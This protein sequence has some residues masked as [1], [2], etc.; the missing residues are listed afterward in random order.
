MYS[1]DGLVI[2]MRRNEKCMYVLSVETRW[3]LTILLLGIVEITAP[4]ALDKLSC[5]CFSETFFSEGI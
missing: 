4:E 5:C 1:L 3:H 2:V